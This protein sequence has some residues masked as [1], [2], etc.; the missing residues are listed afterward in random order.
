[1]PLATKNTAIIVK[2]GKLAESCGCCGGWY[3]CA[4]LSCIPL[5]VS[6]VSVSI[7]AEDYLAKYDMR[8]NLV[9]ANSPYKSS[10]G[11]LG[12]LFSGTR[13]LTK[14]ASTQSPAMS[15]WETTYSGFPTGCGSQ[16]LSVTLNANSRIYPDVWTIL[17]F[18]VMYFHSE[19]QFRS[20]Q[21]LTCSGTGSYTVN[22]G[23]YE[24]HSWPSCSEFPQSL[25]YTR[26]WEANKAFVDQ[27]LAQFGVSAN[28]YGMLASRR[29]SD[30]KY[31][32]AITSVVGRSGSQNVSV[33]ITLS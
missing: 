17:P 10:A 23:L 28:S 26:V 25:S 33:V 14:V 27:Q 3:C 6:S 13:Q 16:T 4:S 31:G 5:D 30:E 11:F 20:L 8:D 15:R 9:S 12:S 21:E 7:T 19:T 24:F 18:P 2:D 1:M 29:G 32:S 22:Y